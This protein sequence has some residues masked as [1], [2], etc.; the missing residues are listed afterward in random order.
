MSDRL[1]RYFSAHEFYLAIIVLVICLLIHFRSDQFFT[2]NNIVNLLT[3]MIVP[4]MFAIGT[5]MALVSGGIDVSFP[6]LAS[7]SIYAV[8]SFLVA[9]E[10]SGSLLLPFLLVVAL[11]ALLGAF[12]GL[13]ISRL[14]VHVL[15]ITLGT[16]NIFR[17]IMRS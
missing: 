12:N 4:G 8:T 3:S 17:G 9:R 1:S 11:G 16:A 13:L 5:H 10:Y 7:L 15:I 6:A 2:A 14:T